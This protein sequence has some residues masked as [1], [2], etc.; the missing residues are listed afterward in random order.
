[1]DTILLD[2]KIAR[3][4]AGAVLCICAALPAQGQNR[5]KSSE[6]VL[7]KILAD[8]IQPEDFGKLNQSAKALEQLTCAK[9]R[10]EVLTAVELAGG[11]VKVIRVTR[12]LR[13]KDPPKAEDLKETVRE[14]WHRKFQGAD[15]RILWSEAVSWSIGS[16]L[17]FEDGKKGILVTDGVHV[18]LQDHDGNAWFFRLLPRP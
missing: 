10:S 4:C 1:M 7:P 11:T 16:V 3:I 8:S 18:A 17:E 5:A 15:C 2:L 14:V 12:T 9:S 13:A 6:D